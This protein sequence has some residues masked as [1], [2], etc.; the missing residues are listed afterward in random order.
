MVAWLAVALWVVLGLLA[1]L[2]ARS[3]GRSPVAWFLL[4]SLLGWWS[5]FLLYLLP[6]VVCDEETA[7]PVAPVPEKKPPVSPLE[8]DKD[9]FF[10]DEAK[11]VCGPVTGAALKEKWKAGQLFPSSWVWSDTIS[12]WKKISQEKTLT[13]WLEG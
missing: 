2:G 3:R 7:V 5:L 9:W 11:K 10:V 13:D 8:Q 4:G 6:P 1:A 12:V